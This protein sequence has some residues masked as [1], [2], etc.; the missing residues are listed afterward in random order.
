MSLN[1]NDFRDHIATTD[2]KGNRNWVYPKKPHGKY[3]NARGFVSFFLLVFLFAAP[4]IKINNEQFL[5][6]NIIDR[7]FIV[8]G[9]TFWPQD[10]YIFVIAMLASLVMIVLFT[11]IFGRLW[12]GW[13]CPQTIFM[14]MVFRKIEYWIEGDS[15]QQKRLDKQIWDREKLLKKL[16]KHI[17]FYVISFLIANTFLAYIIGS[18]QLIQI[19]EDPISKHLTG[20]VAINIFTLLFYGVFARFREQACVI[21]C[22]YGRYQSVMVNEDTIAITYDFDRGEPRAKYSKEENVNGDCIDCDQ[23]VKVCPTGI[24]IRNGI[25]L[26]CVNCTACMDACDDVMVKVN[27][28]PGLIRYSSYNSIKNKAKFQLTT[29]HIAYSILLTLLSAL[30]VILFG[31]RTDLDAIILRQPG[32]LYQKVDENNYSNLYSIKVLN[33]TK[34]NLNGE[35]KL[36][37]NSGEIRFIQPINKFAAEKSNEYRFFVIIP[38]TELKPGENKL[39]FELSVEGNIVNTLR[40]SFIAPDNL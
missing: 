34:L 36:L 26:E 12:C 3:Y 37:R 30:L 18:D 7:H 6:L 35:L 5:L 39:N 40:S 28:E 31:L 19:I 32:I 4:F 14:E 29:R 2:E 13:A 27:R 25:Q 22:P 10:F 15:S 8:F 24:D 1:E 23:C 20:F 33:K 16:S 38:K 9:F 11:S 21:V 17:I